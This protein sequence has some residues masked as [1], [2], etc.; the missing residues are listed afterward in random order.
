[1]ALVKLISMCCRTSC[2]S[3]SMRNEA[4]D[5]GDDAQ[6]ALRFCARVLAIALDAFKRR[7]AVLERYPLFALLCPENLV[8]NNKSGARAPLDRES[9]L[10]RSRALQREIA[11]WT[12]SER[13]P[14]V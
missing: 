8:G 9:D 13:D 12:A 14:I 7:A 1:M 5:E 3:A 4:G 10:Q 11:L 6:C 2:G